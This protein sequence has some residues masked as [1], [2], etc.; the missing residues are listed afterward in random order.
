VTEDAAVSKPSWSYKA[1]LLIFGITA[2]WGGT[3]VVVKDG[4]D[5]AD[6]Y[7]FIAVRFAIGAITLTAFARRQ[8][9]DRDT[10]RAGIGLGLF[11]FLGFVLQTTGLVTTTPSRS[12]F[13]TGLC[14]LL[15]P[16][17]Y[18][19]LFR[20][21]PGPFS[22]A[23]VALA[24]WGLWR[25][26]GEELLQPAGSSTWIG[27]GLTLGCAVAYAFHITLT[28]KL[29]PGRPPMALVAV[30]LWVVAILST[31][32]LPFVERKVEW[33]LSLAGAVLACGLLASAL[34]ISVQTWAQ[35]R[36][37]AVRAALLFS[38]EP[39]FAALI[40]VAM[41]RETLGWREATGGALMVVGV[42]VA[43]VGG[44]W[45]ARRRGLAQV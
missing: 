33:N 2:L 10:L 30:Q 27:D 20:R 15:V 37:T 43:E 4:L 6:P 7:T 23:G 24:I 13:L 14:V 1:D 38:L 45:L 40:S 35:A 29:S 31:L 36:T 17:I 32:C 21:S 5:H 42:I 16:F 11:L 25:L 34:A 18:I 22:A 44:A 3:F 41:G 9:F 39:V 28:E 26:T 8:L 12:A 19:A